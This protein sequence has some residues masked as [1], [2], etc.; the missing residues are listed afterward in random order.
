[1]VTQQFNSFWTICRCMHIY[2]LKFASTYTG[3]ASKCFFIKKKNNIFPAYKLSSAG[4]DWRHHP[5][6]FNLCPWQ[7]AAWIS[8]IWTNLKAY[9]YSLWSSRWKMPYFSL[10][11]S[12]KACQL[13][14]SVLNLTQKY[15]II[16][17]FAF[18][19]FVSSTLEKTQKIF[20]WAKLWCQFWGSNN[21]MARARRVQTSVK[22]LV[23]PCIGCSD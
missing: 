17:M 11:W 1:M 18:S 12:L 10:L 2:Q 8:F 19:S 23:S 16:N 21:F 20:G 13:I 14:L 6:L 7:N 5:F 3:V 15:L 22:Q 9:C 4:Y